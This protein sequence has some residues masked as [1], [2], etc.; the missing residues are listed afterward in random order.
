M[1]TLLKSVDLS[2]SYY[3]VECCQTSFTVLMG[4]LQA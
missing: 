4:Q 3:S 2:E 1:W